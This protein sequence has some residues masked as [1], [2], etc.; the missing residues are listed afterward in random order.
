MTILLALLFTMGQDFPTPNGYINDH[1]GVMK[2]S[3]VRKL[4]S[5]ITE[6]KQ[7]TGAE[8]AFLI[9]PSVKPL[10]IN[11]YANELMEKWAVGDKKKGN[12]MIVVVAIKDRDYAIRTGYGLEGEFPDGKVGQMG[13]DYFV[14]LFQ[15]EKYSE[16]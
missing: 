11:T 12:G 14:P 10:D 15:E 7:K 8:L 1:V 2:S 4:N 13:R 3:D 9:L 6:L 5:V 16:G